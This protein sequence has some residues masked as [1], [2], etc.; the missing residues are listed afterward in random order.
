MGGGETGISVVVPVFNEDEVIAHTLVRL[1]EEFAALG[2]PYEIIAINDGSSDG[3]AGILRRQGGVV[4]VDRSSN[5]GYGYSL[6]EGI[7]IARFDWIF[8]IDA[9]GTYP[10]DQ[11]RHLVGRIRDY[12]MVVG[13]R[14]GGGNVG[15]LNRAAKLVL[16]TIILLLTG[17]W[18]S[19]LNSGMRLFRK[20]LALKYWSILPDRFSFTTT[21]TL[22]STI[23]RNRIY[24]HRISYHKRVGRSSIRPLRD[25]L[26]FLILTIRII[27][28]FK[29][30]N[31]FLATAAVFCLLFVARAIRDI[32]VGDSIGTLA[33]ILFIISVQAFFFG[34][35]AD[36][37]V[38]KSAGG[39]R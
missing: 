2:I 36:L 24:F 26:Y 13:E 19:D 9:D 28:Y 25:F 1:H 7:A 34:L 21:I 18:I 4:L 17:N 27:V 16:R 14:S 30:L 32:I 37:I 20:E 29:P 6:K 11:A 3:T 12:D 22:A 31:V 35:L 5:Y 33:A 23:E 39:R 10:I 15:I 8:I 38:S